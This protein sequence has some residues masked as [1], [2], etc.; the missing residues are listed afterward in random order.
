[1]RVFGIDPWADIEAAMSVV[2]VD[3]ITPEMVRAYL[4]MPRGGVKDVE[5]LV[6]SG[7]QPTLVSIQFHQRHLRPLEG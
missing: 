3:D 4:G 7:L 5:T 2:K 6:R 1:M